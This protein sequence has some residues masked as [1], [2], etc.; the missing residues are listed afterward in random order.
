[1]P[2]AYRRAVGS[3]ERLH[4]ILRASCSLFVVTQPSLLAEL[5]TLEIAATQHP[6]AVDMSLLDLDE[7][8]L[9]CVLYKLVQPGVPHDLLRLGRTCSRLH[10]AVQHADCAWQQ[11][12]QTTYSSGAAPSRSPECYRRLFIDR[13]VCGLKLSLG[14]VWQH[15]QVVCC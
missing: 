3:T 9:A 15:W 10:E 2:G 12:Y 8:A 5:T 4:R 7:V 14:R 1:M 11:L 6:S 13:W